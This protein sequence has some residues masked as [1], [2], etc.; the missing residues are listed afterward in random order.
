M[1]YRPLRPQIALATRSMTS[2]RGWHPQLSPNQPFSSKSTAMSANSPQQETR[3]RK[4]ALKRGALLNDPQ[5]N[6]AMTGP[7]HR[8]SDKFSQSL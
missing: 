5:W 1:L 3:T 6:K 2:N 8:G 7:S 4:V